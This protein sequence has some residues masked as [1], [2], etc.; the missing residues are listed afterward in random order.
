M[1]KQIGPIHDIC[2]KKYAAAVFEAKILLKK[3]VFHDI[4][5]GAETTI[6]LSN[7]KESFYCNFWLL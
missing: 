7:S 2:Q 1:I 5:G 6:K 3:C 4:C